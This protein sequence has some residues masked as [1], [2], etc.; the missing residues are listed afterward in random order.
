MRVEGMRRITRSL[1]W[2]GKVGCFRRVREREMDMSVRDLTKHRYC[3]SASASI[4][5][6]VSDET[7]PYKVGIMIPESILNNM[8][9]DS[10]G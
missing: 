8:N 1:T 6:E 5:V 9:H 10:L 3:A 4:I 7:I 2:P